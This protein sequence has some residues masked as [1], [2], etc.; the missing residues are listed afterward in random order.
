MNGEMRN[1]LSGMISEFV[2]NSPENSLKMEPD[3]KAWDEVLEVFPP[4]LTRFM[5]LTRT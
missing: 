4:G 1:W 2:K 5:R 3:E